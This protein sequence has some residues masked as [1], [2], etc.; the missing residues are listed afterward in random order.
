[1]RRRYGSPPG[2]CATEL[3]L[4]MF[5]EMM[6]MRPICA[7]RP[8][9]A[10]VSDLTKSMPQPRAARMTFAPASADRELDQRETVRVERRHRLVVHL[11]GRHFHHLVFVGHRVAARPDF[12]APGPVGGEL[13]AAARTGDDVIR[14]GRRASPTDAVESSRSKSRAARGPSP[15]NSACRHWRRSRPAPAGA[16]GATACARAASKGSECRRSAS[17]ASPWVPADFETRQTLPSLWLMAG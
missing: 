1:M 8:D 11:V 13:R 10:M 7:R 6:R 15:G 4:A 14:I 5:S 3:A 2:V 12:V 17:A 9:A 16:P